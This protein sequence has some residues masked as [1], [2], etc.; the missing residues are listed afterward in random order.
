MNNRRF[1][2]GSGSAAE[3]GGTSNGFLERDIAC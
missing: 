3:L 1:Q 2:A